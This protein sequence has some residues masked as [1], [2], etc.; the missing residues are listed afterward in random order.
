MTISLAYR[1]IDS[2]PYLTAFTEKS[3]DAL[4]VYVENA[5]GALMRLGN[6]CVK[7]ENGVGRVKL[8]TLSEGVFT[9]EIV[10][11]NKSVFLYPIRHSLGVV[12]LAS[13]DEVC[14]ALG[15]RAYK[16]ECR[17]AALEDEVK[18]LN[19]AVRGKAIF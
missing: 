1:I 18:K 11:K 19:D 4:N 10:F 16:A 17:I 12:T 5:E 14:A 9:P 8:S 15:A 7:I 13:P 6:I 3:G 2:D